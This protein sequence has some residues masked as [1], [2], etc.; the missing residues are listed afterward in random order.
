MNPGP[1]EKFLLDGAAGVV[2]QTAPPPDPPI[3][4]CPIDPEPFVFE[5]E[6]PNPFGP[7]EDELGFFDQ[8]IVVELPPPP[9]PAC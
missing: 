5:E 9:T 2:L 8:L 1:E 4:F 7:V 3:D 6:E